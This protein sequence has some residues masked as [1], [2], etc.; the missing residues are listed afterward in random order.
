MCLQRVTKPRHVTL[1]VT[2]ISNTS[3]MNELERNVTESEKYTNI[4]EELNPLLQSP[5]SFHLQ[6]F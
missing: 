4:P 2:L 3:R 1:G 5:P 6:C